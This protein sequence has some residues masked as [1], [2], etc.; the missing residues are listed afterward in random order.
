MKTN[1]FFDW[2]LILDEGLSPVI[3]EQNKKMVIIDR[4]IELNAVI[5]LDEND[6]IQLKPTWDC[7]ISIDDKNKAI[8]IRHADFLRENN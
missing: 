4:S 1:I 7:V 8:T 5:W 2:T 3:D 6:V